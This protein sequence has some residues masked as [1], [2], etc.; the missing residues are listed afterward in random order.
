MR[1]GDVVERTDG[2][3][4]GPAKTVDELFDLIQSLIDDGRGIVS[5]EFDPDSGLPRT[6]STDPI[7]GA[8]DDEQTYNITSFDFVAACCDPTPT[9][10]VAV[11]CIAENGRLDISLVSTTLADGPTEHELLVGALAP[12]LHTALSGQTITEVVTGRPDGP[13][14]VVLQIDGIFVTSTTVDVDCDPER[15]EV[16]V[17]VSCLA[18]NGRFDIYLS[19][20]ALGGPVNFSYEVRLE[21]D[22]RPPIVRQAEVESGETR[23]VTITGRDDR[24]YTVRVTLRGEQ[25]FAE[26][27]AVTCDQFAEPVEL[28]TSCLAGNGR[29]DIALFNDGDVT[30]TYVVT[31]PPLADRS[32]VLLAGTGATVTYTGRPDVPIEIVV[33]RDGATIFRQIVTPACDIVCDAGYDLVDGACV[34]PNA[35]C[36]APQLELESIGGVP[37]IDPITGEKTAIITYSCVA[38]CDPPAFAN[39]PGRCQIALP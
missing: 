38:S 19:P 29:F 11:S 23:Q 20:R 14:D 36:V 18:E 34:T 32:R 37:F 15:R 31:V 33:T 39:G 2:G 17:D 3:F 28:E 6:I 9:I 7:P 27:F 25:I 21:A 26:R 13:I 24:L 8:V 35:N 30:A 10:N 12:R 22:G 5:A 1:N 16:E 4:L